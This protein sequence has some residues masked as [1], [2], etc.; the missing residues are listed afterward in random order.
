MSSGKYIDVIISQLE[1]IDN[2]LGDNGCRDCNWINAYYHCW[3]LLVGSERLVDLMLTD[4]Q[5]SEIDKLAANGKECNEIKDIMHISYSQAYRHI[6]RV[7]VAKT[8]RERYHAN[9]KNRM[10]PKKPRNNT[11]K[12]YTET[13]K[14]MPPINPPGPFKVIH[15]G[16]EIIEAGP[17]ALGEKLEPITAPLS[18]RKPNM[19]LNC[20]HQIPL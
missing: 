14:E 3:W 20:F 10:K 15:A 17:A 16:R 2:V 5:K 12:A 4:E 18:A 8:A 6:N 7:N 13:V 11:P 19:T 9:P 1:V